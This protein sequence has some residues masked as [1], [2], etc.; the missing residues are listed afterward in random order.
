MDAEMKKNTDRDE[1]NRKRER[2]GNGE[3]GVYM[4]KL[5]YRMKMRTSIL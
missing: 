5:D 2:S 4:E 1:K 3:M